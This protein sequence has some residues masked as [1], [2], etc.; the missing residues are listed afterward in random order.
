MGDTPTCV[1]PQGFSVVDLTW[2]S[3]DLL[4]LIDN[5]QVREDMEWLSDHVCINFNVC[6]G[7]PRLPPIRG[8]NRRWNLRKFDRDFFRA[9][10][11]WSS[12]NP[13]A[14]DVLDLNQSIRNLNKIMEEACDE[15]APR[16]GLRRPRRSAY[17]WS[18]SVAILRTACLHARRCWQCAKRR[19][20][21]S[22]TI[23]ELGRIYKIARKDL[24]L[25]INRP[26][27]KAWQELIES[28]DKDPWDLPYKLVLGKLRTATPGLSELL[29][30]D[31]LSNLLGSLFPRNH[32]PDPMDWSSFDWSD[33]WAIFFEEVCNALKKGSS[34]LSKAPGPD[35]LRLVLWKQAPEKT[36]R[37]V[38]SI[39]NTCLKSGEF[40]VSWKRANLVLIPKANN[41]NVGLQISDTPKAWPI[42]LL[43][44]LGKTFK[45]V[46][47]E[48]IHL[49][50]TSN[51]ESDVSRFQYG[52]RKNKSTCDALLLVREIT[53]TA[54]KNGGFAFAVSLDISNAYNSIPWRKIKALRDDGYPTYIRRVLDSYFSDGIIR[55]LDKDGAPLTGAPGTWRPEFRKAQCSVLYCGTSRLTRS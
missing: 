29:K 6:T 38:T 1:R 17:W 46:L 35:G 18:E 11:I 31:V 9:A 55:Y 19:S 40:L 25:E 4:P 32:L 52:F 12:R 34:S 30:Q 54:V 21:S 2:S 49:W 8:L 14:E 24:R 13:D 48:R 16:I 43:D 33:D 22:A 3:P 50:Q 36:I 41:S 39:F 51:P 27:T 23:N 28:I 5:W 26:K 42:C 47:A 20:R 53:S 37:W 10:L 45:R 7:R 44:E 15:A